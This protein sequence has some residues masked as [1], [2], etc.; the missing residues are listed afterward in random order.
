MPPVIY[1]RM[2]IL[3]VVLLALSAILESVAWIYG[4]R[5]GSRL[6]IIVLELVIVYQSYVLHKLWSFLKN[7]RV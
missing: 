3:L 5:R 2:H 4:N 7:D 6:L 1:K